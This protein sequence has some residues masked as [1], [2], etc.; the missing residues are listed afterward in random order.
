MRALLGY[1]MGTCLY[2]ISIAVFSA[3]VNTGLHSHR[4]IFMNKNHFC[5]TAQKVRASFVQKGNRFRH[6][7][8]V[9]PRALAHPIHRL[10]K[11]YNA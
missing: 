3:Y 4:Y 2:D 10:L 6:F 9:F 11:G 8:C 7:P 1:C 5:N